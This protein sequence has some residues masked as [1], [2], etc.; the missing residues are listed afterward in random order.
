MKTQKKKIKFG[1]FTEE[2]NRIEDLEE[3]YLYEDELKEFMKQKENSREG[4]SQNYNYEYNE[5]KR[6]QK[7]MGALIEANRYLIKNTP[8][9]RNSKYYEYFKILLTGQEKKAKNFYKF[10]ELDLSKIR[11]TLEPTDTKE[12]MNR[13]FA[14]T[15]LLTYK[16]EKNLGILEDENEYQDFLESQFKIDKR[17]PKNPINEEMNKYL[18]QILDV[19]KT[20]KENKM[21]KEDIER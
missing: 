12:E 21:N 16:H 7:E 5:L 9:Y 8:N 19:Y 4:I 20:N 17:D 15:R 2:V 13:K 14:M 10:H 1:S 6:K 3:V 11:F 18:A